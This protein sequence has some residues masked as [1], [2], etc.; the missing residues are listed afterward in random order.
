M[1]DILNIALVGAGFHASTTLLPTLVHLPVRLTAVVDRDQEKAQRV[2]TQFSCAAYTETADCY[3]SEQLDAVLLCVGP[4]QHPTLISEALDVGLHVWTEKP[5]SLT[6]AP[7]DAIA[8]QVTSSDKVC[9]VGYKKAFMPVV[10][11]IQE[12]LQREDSGAIQHIIAQYPLSIPGGWHANSCHPLSLMLAC[13]GPIERLRVHLAANKGGTLS[14]QFQDGHIGTLIMAA[15]NRGLSER[16]QVIC[17][18]THIEVEDGNK[19]HWHRGQRGGDADRWI[20]EGDD[21]GTITWQVQ[22]CYARRDNRLE[23]TQGFHHEIRAFIDTVHNGE[24]PALGS[25]AFARALT[26]INELV[27]ANPD[28]DQW[29]Q[30]SSADWRKSAVLAQA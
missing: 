7:L 8:D 3:A 27:A 4:G 24:R 15:G 12:I 5:A 28:S 6:T 17:E 13:G 9:M 19:L 23:M 26:E 22:N 1:P 14:L 10:H 21:H 25:L 29:L 30:C 16:Y 18:N 11:K 20:G 2:A